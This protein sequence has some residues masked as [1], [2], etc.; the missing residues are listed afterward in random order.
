MT[1]ARLRLFF[2]ASIPGPQLKELED[3]IQAL[4]AQLPDARWASLSNQH[5]TLKFLG[6]ADPSLLADIVGVMDDVASKHSPSVLR[7]KGAGAFPSRNRARVVWA[8]IEDEAGL[9]ASLANSLE[10][11]LE[12][13]GFEREKRAYTPHLTVARI[14]N[15]K[16]VN[17]ES[18]SVDTESWLVT[19]IELFRSHLSPRGARYE[20]LSSEQLG[21]D[22]QRKE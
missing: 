9:L 4:R 21:R 12:P 5:I 17:L 20:V 13:L 19:T 8:G 16:A 2:A 10:E 22:A 6:W 1:A 15:P 14:K 3:A 7:L 18:T 11:Q